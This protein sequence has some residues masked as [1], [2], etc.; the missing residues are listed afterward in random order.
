MQNPDSFSLDQA[1]ALLKKYF[2]YDAF[3]PAQL[4]IMDD[5]ITK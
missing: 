2:G 3:R 1:A 4:A 5:H